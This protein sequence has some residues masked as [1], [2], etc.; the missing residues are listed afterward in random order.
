LA[1]AHDIA[2]EARHHL[3]HQVRRLSSI[4]IHTSPASRPGRD[5][6]AITSHHFKR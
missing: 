6:H 3:L 4:T 5:P 1:T 2:E